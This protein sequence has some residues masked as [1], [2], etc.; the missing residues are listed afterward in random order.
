MKRL[1]LVM[2]LFF[3]LA[4]GAGQQPVEYRAM[5]VTRYELTSTQNISE[6]INKAVSNNFNTLFVQVCGRGTAFYNSAILPKDSAASGFDPLADIL[7]KAKKNNIE[8]HAWVNTL[9]VWSNKEK[10][11][12]ADH[13][14]NQHQNWLLCYGQNADNSYFLNPAIPEVRQ[15]V[16]DVCLEIANKYPVTGIHIDYT[17][18]PGKKLS[19][20]D[21]YSCRDFEK[22]VGVDPRA[23]LKNKEVATRLYGQ[24]EYKSYLEK[25]GQYNRDN[26]SELVKNIS[27]ALAKAKPSVLFSAAVIA[28]Y[29]QANN[30][31]YQDWAQWMADGYVDLIV[32]MAYS[33]R[34]DVVRKQVVFA[35]QLA[36]KYDR[37]LLIGLGAWQQSP[38]RIVK[39]IKY[40]QKIREQLKFGQ[41]AGVVLFS[42]DK[43]KEGTYLDKIR[44]KIFFEQAV[45]P[46]LT[47]NKTRFAEDAAKQ[48]QEKTED[49]EI[50]LKYHN[51]II[52]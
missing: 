32:P 22:K 25:W 40:T 18:L 17:R 44:R 46:E 42:Y 3:T 36:E 15:H 35:T 45:R 9:Y 28:D 43:I 37:S 48:K 26:I 16:T 1:F 31:F 5:W 29:E 52:G 50:D 41:V 4:F 20:N 47:I 12:A 38:E 27:Q 13:V 23:L 6:I 11:T 24:D 10:P 30:N 14:V 33:T 49:Q 51:N 19:D 8:I 21:E 39:H 2:G 7:E 34:E